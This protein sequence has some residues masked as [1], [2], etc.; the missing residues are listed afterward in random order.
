M[1]DGPLIVGAYLDN[2]GPTLYQE[3]L[4]DPNKQAAFLFDFA[5]QSNFWVHARRAG[6]PA[7][8][9]AAL[10]TQISIIGIA[11]AELDVTGSYQAFNF[12]LNSIVAS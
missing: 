2:I 10:N 5:S 1:E 12:G 11:G 3:F 7:P 8:W 6:D 9:P 4:I